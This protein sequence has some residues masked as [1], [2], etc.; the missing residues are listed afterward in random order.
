MR[1]SPRMVAPA[2]PRTEAICGPTDLS[3]TSRLPTSSSVTSAAERSP[4]RTRITGSAASVSGSAVGSPPRN[5][6][7]VLE[8]VQLA[9]VLEGRLLLG[10]VP[11]DVGPRGRRATPSTVA[12]GSA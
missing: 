5:E 1:P 3:T 4:A 8:A 10:K 7:E 12:T 9:R 11:R 2:M 6:D